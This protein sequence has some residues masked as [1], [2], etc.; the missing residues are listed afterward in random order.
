MNYDIL[1]QDDSIIW[2]GN[3]KKTINLAEKLYNTWTDRQLLMDTEFKKI[4]LT[5]WRKYYNDELDGYWLS[6]SG[7]PCT[8]AGIRLRKMTPLSQEENE[9]RW[10]SEVYISSKEDMLKKAY[11]RWNIY[12]KQP[13]QISECDVIF[14]QSLLDY[15]MESINLAS[16][17][18]IKYEA[19]NLDEDSKNCS[20]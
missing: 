9:L 16:K 10:Y 6:N 20:G 15:H 18:G 1:T 3:L 7:V 2:L 4:Y 12:A 5:G 11:Q 19:F 13:F 8:F 17:I 14:Y